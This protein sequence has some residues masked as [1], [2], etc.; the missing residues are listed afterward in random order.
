MREP[1]K[2]DKPMSEKTESII[3]EMRDKSESARLMV[4]EAPGRTAGKVGRW[5]AGQ[6]Q[7]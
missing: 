3:G 4:K 6:H 1:L 7:V 5:P 2:R